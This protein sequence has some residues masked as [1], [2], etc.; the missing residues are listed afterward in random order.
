MAS[1]TAQA[2]S[3]TAAA[4]TGAFKKTAGFIW[5][6]VNPVSLTGLPLTIGAS[7]IFVGGAWIFA[8][9]AMGAVAAPLPT[10]AAGS[11]IWSNVAT[12]GSYGFNQLASATAITANGLGT[13]VVSADYAG[14]GTGLSDAWGAL[15]A[16]GGAAAGAPTPSAA[17]ILSSAAGTTSPAV[18]AFPAAAAGTTAAPGAGS[19]L[20]SASAPASSVLPAGANPA[21]FG[22]GSTFGGAGGGMGAAQTLSAGAASTASQ[23]A[24]LP[25][26]AL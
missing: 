9:A 8:P 12:V 4:A 13:T 5:G 18:G 23:G 15:T 20:A 1:E 3:E 25:A 6:R 22:M 26:H 17:T 14:I 24:L 21:A 11:G 10:L 16:G 7:A 19:V 2:A